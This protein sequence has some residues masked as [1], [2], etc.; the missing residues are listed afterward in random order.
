[1]MGSFKDPLNPTLEE[2]FEVVSA[3][4]ADFGANA[5]HYLS[6]DYSE[7]QARKDFVDQFLIALGWDVN[8]EL[9]K[10]PY[11]Q[12]VKVERAVQTA[13]A[14]RHADYGLALAPHFETPVLYV[15]AKKPGADIAAPNNCFQTI[16]YANQ[17][18]HPIGVLT[19]FEEF[20]VI[21]CRYLANIDTATQCV[22]QKHHF[23]K[24]ADAETF[25]KI[26]YLVSR[27]E[28][29]KGSIERYADTLPKPTKRAG[30]QTLGFVPHKPI[31][32]LLLETLD[33]LRQSLARN[34]KLR[35]HELDS[36][37]LTEITQRILDRLVLI[38]FLED[39]LIEP[40][41]IIPK[42][43]QTA[44]TAWRDFLGKSRL[45]D[46]IYNGVVFKRHET[47]DDPDGLAI[48][49]KVFTDV[50]GHFD[51]HNSKYLFNY[52]PIHILGSIYER[53][54]E[55]VIVATAKRADLKPKPEVRKAG[56]V[57]Y[58]PKYI[59]DYIVANT[60]ARLVEGK[61]PV[62]ISKMRFA[63]IACGSGS[64]L[65]GAYDCLLKY[66][67][68]WYGE[69]P[70]RV[71]KGAVV[72]RDDGLS[73]SLEEKARILTDNIY[74]V[75]IDP[76]AIEVTQLSLYLKLLEEETT[77]SARQYTLAFHRPLLP[78]LANNIKCGNSI[79]GDDF[80]ADRQPDMLDLDTTRKIHTL[81]WQTEFPEVFKCGGFD[82][83]LGNPPYMDSEWMT[84]YLKST[85]DYCVSRYR[86]A[87]GNWDLFCVFSE[88]AVQLCRR[89][90]MVSFIVPN[91]LG[92]A[93]YASGIRRVLTVENRLASIRDYSHVPVFPV[94]VYPIVFVVAREE[95]K[96]QPA[97]VF[98][99]R[100]A[101]QGRGP[102]VCTES[103]NLPYARYFAQPNTPW[104]IFSGI[105]DS[106]VIAKMRSFS[107]LESVAS[108]LGAATVAEAYE[109]QNLISEGRTK[110]SE[111]VRVVNSGTI[112][113]YRDLWAEKPL[114]YLGK[115][116]VY[117][118]I[119]KTDVMRL[120]GKRRSQ[121]L[122]P[123]IIV[124]GMTKRLECVIDSEGRVLAGKSTTVVLPERDAY[125]LLA[126]LNSK[127]AS[128]FYSS[129]FGGNK[130]QGGYLRIGPPQLRT[131]PIPALDLSR[132]RPIPSGP[133]R[134]VRGG[135]AEI[136]RAIGGNAS[137]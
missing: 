18:G 14:Q 68:R 70:S 58:T 8:H 97:N 108:V 115:S 101:A 127:A 98:Y 32:A 112:D 44:A 1:M 126:V 94:S 56:G 100:V 29:A 60:V 51:Y 72:K 87:S 131:V 27:P 52:I 123:K 42:L 17:K 99:E 107:P 35:N 39:K 85:R 88:K 25:A 16:R 134:A 63:D 80:Y 6:G 53:F 40:V 122:T 7:A 90:G 78:S 28:V 103:R 26:Y 49:D 69:H 61:T 2:A 50:L 9:Q 41:P 19:S 92:S 121:A 11:Q 46:G 71:S 83:V 119:T 66:V 105:D 3:L 124:A 128:F 77:A 73:L 30:Q 86:A 135:D 64:F 130:L 12:E 13:T 120:P 75:D 111:A 31:D 55:N 48:D 33:S 38:R 36:A 110:D 91:K 54:L 113:R 45:L 10:N 4:A 96:S 76:Q 104:E 65:L 5:K 125:Y 15:E 93:E 47:L 102:A 43:G 84:G 22:L 109:I 106:R 132:Q 74:G 136:A 89:G 67:S 57:Y 133:D 137:C 116:Y 81:N 118:V 62:E 21:D 34:L 82:A 23:S 129:V 20:L 37:A 79:V 24:Y 117:P 95:P 114:R 59:V